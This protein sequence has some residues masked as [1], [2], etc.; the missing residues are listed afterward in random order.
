G[1]PVIANSFAA[2]LWKS[3]LDIARRPGDFLRT[4]VLPGWAGRATILLVMQTVDNRIRLRLGRSRWTGGRRDLVSESDPE[5]PIPVH[6]PI[7][8]EVTRRFAEKTGGI[9]N[10]TINEG[11]LNTPMTA[12]VLGGC[13]YGRDAS[14]GVIGVDAQVHGYPGLYVVDGAMLPANPG[15]NPILTIAAMAELAMSRIPPKSGAAVRAPVGVAE[16]V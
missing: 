4:H 8:H 9:P 1:P 13:P 3:L 14:E 12:H 10:G 6:L 5:H 15:V 7:A 16:A 2:R 11:L